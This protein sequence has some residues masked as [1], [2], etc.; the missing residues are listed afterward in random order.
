MVRRRQLSDTPIW[1]SVALIMFREE[2]E[3]FW[4]DTLVRTNRGQT[5][6]YRKCPIV[7]W[8]KHTPWLWA[9]TVTHRELRQTITYFGYKT[10]KICKPLGAHFNGDAVRAVRE[11]TNALKAAQA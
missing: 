11:A 10:C 3:L 1:D 9:E 5:V 2:M 6:H 7:A 8:A 4:S